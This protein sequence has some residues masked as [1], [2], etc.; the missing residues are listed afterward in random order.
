MYQA[1]SYSEPVH[2]LNGDGQWVDIDN[3]LYWNEKSGKYETSDGRLS[4]SRNSGG[5]DLYNISNNGFSISLSLL[6]DGKKSQDAVI[7]NHPD[8]L[9]TA[10]NLKDDEKLEALKDIDNRTKVIYSDAVTGI[11]IKYSVNAND[12]KE[13]IIIKEKTETNEFRFR[14]CLKGLYAELYNGAVI[15][16]DENGTEKYSCPPPFMY[17]EKNAVSEDVRYSLEKVSEEE[18]I[19]IVSADKEWLGSDEREYPVI[20]DPSF[21][22]SSSYYLDTYIDSYNATTSYAASTQLWISS[23]R[24]SLLSLDLPTLGAYDKIISGTFRI[25]YH[26]NVSTGSLQAGIYKVLYYYYDNGITYA[27]DDV[28]WEI[29]NHYSNLGL[30]TD[31]YATDTV[32]ADVGINAS[33][34]GLAT[35]DITELIQEWYVFGNNM[36]I[37]IKRTGGPNYSV[38]FESRESGFSNAAR[39]EITYENNPQTISNGTYF[40]KNKRS[41]KYADLANHAIINGAYAEQWEFTGGNAQKWCFK[42][43]HIGDYFTIHCAQSSSYYLAVKDNSTAQDARV[44]IRTATVTNNG[45]KLSDGMLWKIETTTSG[46]YKL[47]PKTGE[48]INET[49]VLAIGP[50]NPDSN[51][52]EIDQRKYNDDTNYKDEWY[53]YEINRIYGSQIHRV[54]TAQQ[55]EDINCHGYAML[56]D[57]WPWAVNYNSIGIWWYRTQLYSLTVTEINSTVK[58]AVDNLTKA[59]FEEWLAQ[60]GYTWVYESDFSSNGENRVIESNQ[61]RVVLRAGIHFLTQDHLECDYHFWYQTYDG[62]WSNKHGNTTEINLGNGITPFT[63]GTS[64]WSLKYY[65]GNVQYTYVDFYNGNIYSYIITID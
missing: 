5:E 16:K 48:G 7:E 31:C 57:D 63:Q 28:T 43:S 20:I 39:Y 38:I 6:T 22:Y 17:D 44:V 4:F 55:R 21:K 64:G 59:D 60:C 52:T 58:Q 15:L 56:R 34:P 26:Y 30:S 37:A 35:F 12:V 25:K 40:L 62:T 18:Y 50:N 49:K 51:G 42:Y 3:R 46:A 53:L 41:G 45:K 23:S 1:V 47:T 54:L 10:E 9:K 2:Y 19:L 33:N 32:A 24:V 14:L 36:G 65:I 27:L 13:D 8:R 61:Y 11:D 29:A